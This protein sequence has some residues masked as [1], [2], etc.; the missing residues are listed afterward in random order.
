[1]THG[2]HTAFLAKGWS[3]R[4][5]LA[6]GGR[7]GV[8]NRVVSLEQYVCFV[9]FGSFGLI[10]IWLF[11]QGNFAPIIL[12][13]SV[14]ALV[15]WYLVRLYRRSRLGPLTMLLFVAYA[16]PFI[17]VIPYLWF[18][19]DAESPLFLWGL[20]ANPYMTDSRIIELTSMIGAIGA[21]G[22]A[23]GASLFQ[24]KSSL[25]LSHEG[26]AH[27]RP[28]RGTLSVAVFLGWV[29]VAIALSWISAPTDTVFTAA[30]TGSKA[31]LESWNFASAWMLSYALLVF[32]LADSMFEHSV[33]VGR[34]KRRVVLF[35]IL[36]IVIWFQ[37]LRG[38]R[39]SLPFVFAAMLMYYVWGNGLLGSKKTSVR[40]N[41]PIM[42]ALAL[43][44]F[45]AAFF[46]G[47][48]RN[49]LTGVGDFSDLLAAIADLNAA[50]AFRLDNLVS[51]TWSAVLLTP[52]SVAGD[53]INDS[54]P[55]Q[56]GQT[57]VDLLASTMPGFLAD[58][59]G[60][61]RPI[62]AFR[63]PAWEMTFGMGGTHA[64]VVPFINFRMAGVFVILAISSLLFSEIERYALRRVTVSNLALLG[65]I[66]MATPHW[67]WY[68]EK[69][70]MTALI[71]WLVLANFYNLRLTETNSGGNLSGRSF[72]RR[73]L[74]GT[75]RHENS[76]PT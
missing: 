74:A 69:N 53:Y 1:M 50:G 21:A 48:A 65:T 38:D 30:Y 68:G 20:M 72:R 13:A 59:V 62:D 4:I 16:L 12:S 70:I 46:V 25:I 66:A 58:W 11:H 51:G 19:F 54:L 14:F 45:G 26:I 75:F 37:I 32:A 67:L 49:A 22:F 35:S 40:I 29:G 39:D 31:T 60:Y 73:F 71:I 33:A 36:V 64:V 8:M 17:H 76:P 9:L 23:V 43:V 44:I 28:T 41:R 3:E 47:A 55:L 5:R 6:L 34:F 2:W 18:D 42:L 56:Y 61:A 24:R 27:F 63:G 52:L 15:T 57:Y 7:C 10:G